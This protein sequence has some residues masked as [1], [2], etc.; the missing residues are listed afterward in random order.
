MGYLESVIAMCIGDL[1]RDY[2]RRTKLGIV[3]GEAGMMRLAAGLVRIPDVSVVL[4][5]RLPGH[6][7]PRDPIPSLAPDLAVEVLST[8]NTS[9]E[10]DLKIGEYFAA[11][12]RCVWIVEPRGR[13]VR[14]YG[15]R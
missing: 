5:E 3:A 7:I 1:L 11:G 4:W 15:S 2:M 13:V 14:I 9:E 8:S 12:C 10:M 6:Q